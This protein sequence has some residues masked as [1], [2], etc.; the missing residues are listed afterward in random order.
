MKKTIEQL[1]RDL[2]GKEMSFTA[3]DNYM[4][5]SGYYSVEDDGVIDDIKNVNK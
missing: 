1:K 5:G 2:K 3:L 4:A